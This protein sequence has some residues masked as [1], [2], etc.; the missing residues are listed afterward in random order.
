[1]PGVWQLHIHLYAYVSPTY[2][3]T[4]S[5]SIVKSSLAEDEGERI[6]R[7]QLLAFQQGKKSGS[8]AG[9]VAGSLIAF[10]FPFE[11]LHFRETVFG[12][13]VV[14]ILLP[15]AGKEVIKNPGTRRISEGE[16]AEDD[17]KGSFLKHTAP[18][19]DGRSYFQ[20]Q[21]EQAGAQHAGKE[22]WLGPKNRIAFLQNRIRL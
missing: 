8:R 11:R 6:L 7:F 16:P 15:N 4:P 14:L 2:T 3:G 19:S 13:E 5:S 9:R 17:I 1:M 21:G 10:L 20:F 18:D 12:R 22:P